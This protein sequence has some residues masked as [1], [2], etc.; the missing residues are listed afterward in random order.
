MKLKAKLAEPGRLLNWQVCVIPSAVSVQAIAAAGADIVIIDQEHGAI[1][2]ESLHGMI[3]ATQGT[4]CAPLVRIPEISEAHVK[5]ALD[6]GA[7][8]I[9]F[10]LLRSAED[11]RR[12]VAAMR[13]PPEGVRGFGPFVAQSRWGTDLMGYA[14]GVARDVVCLI[15]IETREALEAIEEIV[16][17][18]GVDAVVIASFDLSTDLGV[19]GE[20][21]HP[22][23]RS[24]VARIE[25]AVL[26]A[27]LP[28]GAIALTEKA[29]RDLRARGYRLLGG[30]D[31]LW[32]KGA[33][34]RS[35]GWLT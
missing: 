24:A 20:M 27:G 2:P 19:M 9:C 15:L 8:G 10:P 23:M 1:G 7:E 35:V 3:A 28:L 11:A 26:G 14:K 30:F 17:V 34:Q 22:V 18:E 4:G 13:Y 5:W 25:A 12:C 31:L 21:E 29:T 16:A 33:V 6:A 32:L